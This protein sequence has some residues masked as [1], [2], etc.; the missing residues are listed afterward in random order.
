VHRRDRAVRARHLRHLHLGLQA[1]GPSLLNGIVVRGLVKQYG[2][3][4]RRALDDVSLDIA[5]GEAIGIIG[6]NGAGKTT[7][8]GCLLGHLRPTAGTITIDGLSPDAMGIKAA[9]GFLPERLLFDRWMSGTRFLRHHHALAGLPEASRTSDCAAAME[10]VGLEASAGRK[11]LK[12]YSRGMLQRIGLAQ[13]LLARPR[14][15]FLDEPASG[16]DP[17]GVLLFRR[18]LAEARAGGATIVLNSHQLDQVERI[19]DRVAFLREGKVQSIEVLHA[20]AEAKRHLRVRFGA[21]AQVTNEAL[22]GVGELVHPLTTARE[23]VF[24]V[25]DDAGATRLLGALLAASLPVVEARSE[26]G[27]LERLFLEGQPGEAPM[28]VRP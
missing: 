12:A 27:R 19:C 11:A 16:V 6:P 7:F 3:A 5:P 28:E 8:F 25:A 13:A 14:F 23:A 17:A 2:G 10:K 20:G 1:R 15:L 21:G 22:A 26:E 4:A 24:A 18:L 9:V